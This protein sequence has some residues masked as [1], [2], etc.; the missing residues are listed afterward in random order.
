MA[1]PKF[2]SP[3]TNP[4]GLKDVGSNAVPTFA[5]IDGDGDSDAFIGASNGKIDFFRN[6][7]DNTTPSFTEESDNFG[8]TNVGLYAA[9][10]FF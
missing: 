4:F 6:T 8:L 7:G 10:T 1:E 3:T 2:L 9:P 5:D